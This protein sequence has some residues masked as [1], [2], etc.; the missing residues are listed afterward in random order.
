MR[1]PW[2]PAVQASISSVLRSLPAT[3]CPSS[4]QRRVLASSPPSCCS[5]ESAWLCACDRATS[6]CHTS[7]CARGCREAA[8]LHH[9]LPP[10]VFLPR[11]PPR[12]GVLFE[13]LLVAV[14]T[15]SR[16][17]R[18]RGMPLREMHHGAAWFDEAGQAVVCRAVG[19]LS[20]PGSSRQ[21]TP[22]QSP[23]QRAW[24]W[25]RMRR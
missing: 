19:A 5:L 11:A 4:S 17:T 15:H 16:K 20:K 14:G 9:T 24:R 18:I 3:R 13:I 21:H 6:L 23:S 8:L 10:L 1:P 22:Q 2:R 25:P 7:A 12:E